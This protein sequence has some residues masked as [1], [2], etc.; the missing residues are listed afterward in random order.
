MTDE[1]TREILAMIDR[2][3]VRWRTYGRVAMEYYT[4]NYLQGNEVILRDMNNL[5]ER[6]WYRMHHE[7][8]DFGEVILTTNGARMLNELDGREQRKTIWSKS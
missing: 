7:D 1:R 4:G 2:G 5:S 3:E 6:L 8:S